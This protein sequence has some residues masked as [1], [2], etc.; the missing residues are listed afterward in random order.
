MN[1]ICRPAILLDSIAR[2]G[3]RVPRDRAP[4]VHHNRRRARLPAGP[5]A[6]AGGV[7]LP[8]P[9]RLIVMTIEAVLS[10]GIWLFILLAFILDVF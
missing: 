4:H 9:V 6:I 7:F 2:V 10:T 8:S 3:R 1:N 5:M